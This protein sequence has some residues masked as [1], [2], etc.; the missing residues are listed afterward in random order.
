MGLST[1]NASALLKTLYSPDKVVNAQYKKSPLFAMLA[2]FEE[3]GGDGIK[4]PII[5]GNPASR[6][7]TFSTAQTLASSNNT[8]SKAF[9]VTHVTDYAVAQISGSAIRRSKNDTA[10]FVRLAKTEIDGAMDQLVRSLCQKL[11]RAGWGRVGAISSS[12]NLASTTLLL[13]APED[14]ANFDIG[15]TIVFAATEAASALRTATTLTVTAVDRDAGTIT[16]NNTPNSLSAS[17]A[18]GD[19]IFL[20]GDRQNSGSPTRLAVAGLEAWVP[21]TAPSASESFFGVDRSVDPVRLAGARYAP[22][23]LSPEDILIEATERVHRSGFEIKQI[24]CNPTFMRNLI[25]SLG[26]NVRRVNT[27][28]TQK[29]SFQAIEVIGAT[30]PVEVY[31]DVY[32]PSNRVFGVNLD[33]WTLGSTG[34]AVRILNEDGQDMLRQSSSDGYEVRIGFE[35]NLWCK[36]PVA[37]INVAV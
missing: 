15:N 8:Q 23:N 22:T 9:T 34:P 33:M 6:S 20:E 11:Y 35:G 32:C 7:T 25:K 18:T 37:Y 14:A 17:V 12:A 2:K 29:V 36:G 1:S 21:Q 3:F 4:V 28:V 26:A 27:E 13:S 31:S 30:G 10:A 16:L 19:V 24:F 5:H